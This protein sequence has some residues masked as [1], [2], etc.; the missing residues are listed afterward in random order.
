MNQ[1]RLEKMREAQRLWAQQPIR[2][3]LR[4][5]R[6]LREL[7]ASE[8]EEVARLVPHNTAGALH[9]TDAETLVA[10][11]LPLA[12][13]CRFLEREAEAILRKRR[14]GRQGRPLW[15]TG[16][17]A[18]IER[19]PLGIVLLVAP[20]NYPLLLAGVQALQALAAGDAV[21]W[22]PAPGT[23]AVAERFADMLHKCGLPEALLEVMDGD[24][25]A[26]QKAIRLGVDHVVLTGSAKTGTAVLHQTAETLTPATMELSGWDAVFVLRGADL[27]RV[28][29]AVVFGMR[30]NGSFTCMAPR[31]MILVGLA[32]DQ[33][34]WLET[35][36]RIRL[37]ALDAVAISREGHE[38][39]IQMVA[40]AR[41]AQAEIALDGSVLTDGRASTTLIL[42]AHPKMQ[43]M[44]GEVFAPVLSVLRTDNLQQA[45][46]AHAECAFGL[47]ASIFGPIPAAKELTKKLRVGHVVIQDLM[48]PTADPR[49]SFGGVG[50]GGFGVTR[51]RDGLLA[52]TRARV[53][54]TQHRL[55]RRSYERIGVE[56]TGLFAGMICSL[57]AGGMAA[58]LQGMRQMV[59][60]AMDL[61]KKEKARR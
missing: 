22:K 38:K 27:E 17:T 61:R 29:Q 40:D 2:D 13:A 3:R 42:S 19:V 12:A 21:A 36:L 45:V 53:V 33:A 1:A 23:E 35:E 31:R 30:F 55:S 11:V 5:I 39:L 48:T 60:A 8:P 41:A 24:A 20:G 44:R 37:A 58:R 18:E 34:Q 9:R 43:A 16:V 14:M 49:V 26:V 32:D 47:T 56:H 7:I 57:Y 10:E 51:G 54:Q 50:R 28:A 15:L 4:V 59:R 6:K 46:E 25:T 52:M